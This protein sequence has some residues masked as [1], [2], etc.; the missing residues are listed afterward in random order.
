V[1]FIPSKAL[2][3]FKFLIKNLIPFL[4]IYGLPSTLFALDN[5]NDNNPLQRLWQCQ[6][7]NSLSDSTQN[8]AQN[9]TQDKSWSCKI[10]PISTSSI[11][12]T[13][14]STSESS[15]QKKNI[16]QAL[17]WIPDTTDTILHQSKTQQCNT[18][19][20]HYYLP[21]LPNPEE[22]NKP[23]NAS[24][25]N[26]SADQANY[27]INGE[28]TLTGHVKVIQPGRL[29]LADTATIYQGQ[30]DTLFGLPQQTSK[31]S[32]QQADRVSRITAD[33]NLSIQ[34]PD[35]L[36]LADHLD[37]EL[38]NHKTEI[39]NAN[40]LMQLH[41]GF[42]GTFLGDQNFTGFAHGSAETA[43]QRSQDIYDF[44]NASYATCP[45][46]DETWVLHAKHIQLD[47][48]SERGYASNVL[49]TSHD[50]PI[51]YTPY[52]SF[53]L[54]KDRQSGFL[55]GSVGYSAGN[56]NGSSITAPY[57]FNLAPNY[58]DTLTPTI[59]QQR[60]L[61]LSNE[62]RYLTENSTGDL[63]LQY[64]YDNYTESNRGA[65]K[66]THETQL[67]PNWD[68]NGEYNYLSDKNFLSDFNN[69]YAIPT[70][71][72]EVSGT[73]L[74]TQNNVA[75]VP[76]NINLNYSSPHW[77]WKNNFTQYQIIDKTFAL[78]NRPYNLLPQ[79]T[80]IGSFPAIPDGVSPLDLNFFGQ[81]TNFQKN[82]TDTES[83]VNGQ[84]LLLNPQINLPLTTSYG[85]I[86]P[87]ITLN[88]SSYSLQNISVNPQ[89]TTN[90]IT[91]VIPQLDV[92]SGLYF[93][94]DFGLFDKKYSQ[95]LE[96]EV[97]YL[98]TPN[99]NQNNI[100][101]F[102]TAPISFDYSQ[103][104][105]FNR[106]AGYDRIGDTSQISYALQSAVNN[107]QG[108][109]LFQV[110][111]GQIYYFKDR[112]TTLCYPSDTCIINENPNYNQ[113]S[114]PIA[115]EGSISLGNA[116][117]LNASNAYNTHTKAL[118]YQ[119]YGAQYL[120]DPQ[121]VFNINYVSNRQDYSLLT[122]DQ[123][124]SGTAPPASKQLTTSTIWKL[125]PIWHLL[126][127]WDYS[128]DHQKTVS[129][130]AAIEYNQCCFAIQLGMYRYLLTNNPNDPSS[131][132][133][134]LQTSFV[135]QIVLKG[136]GGIGE[137]NFQ[138]LAEQIPGYSPQSEI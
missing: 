135:G 49:L 85:F 91:N 25:S 18:C 77:N 133:G 28:G 21:P 96:P 31:A 26:I 121:H 20:G 84:R 123:I 71:A 63:D 1:N 94:R 138:Q 134:S 95:T 126:G 114:S 54:T 68:L 4:G 40:Y 137:N 6:P 92:N 108:A 51:F 24:P 48:K 42:N 80:L 37:A 124:L 128:L 11:S 57:Y 83:A 56:G 44:Y 70:S 15:S 10:L 117:S 74:A 131:L 111:I 27:H 129:E 61:L 112:H 86:T 106:F 99:I 115:A 53:P 88:N 36:V 87:G 2:I 79:S 22:A 107:A 119:S 14:T 73:G 65:V 105:A 17:G 75:V 66:Y 118:T 50:I 16:S 58:D 39:K 127:D 109:Q 110:G 101:S 113:D 125:T 104:F 41:P 60:G 23:I 100:P 7:Q 103:L 43:Y 13:S 69:L 55:Y 72:T 132:S 116:W 120:P 34:Q 78:G 12:S 33:G 47:R 93:D 122:Q 67:S 102:D 38:F 9:N 30:P 64:I 45:P 35:T 3:Y 19:G 76:R 136:L 97:M 81:L 90:Q 59:Y 130:F 29:L 89:L 62:F 98:F 82:S 52:F 46:G 32:T 8:N 5:S